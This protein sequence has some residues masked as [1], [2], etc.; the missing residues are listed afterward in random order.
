M[1][2]AAFRHETFIAPILAGQDEHP[3]IHVAARGTQSTVV[4][5]EIIA[6]CSGLTG[7]K[8]IT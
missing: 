8:V 3:G 4:E 1:S 5:V 2:M 7:S 6:G